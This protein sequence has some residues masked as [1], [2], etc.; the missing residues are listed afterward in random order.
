MT[1][2]HKYSSVTIAFSFLD[3]EALRDAIVKLAMARIPEQYKQYVTEDMVREHVD[4]IPEEYLE[5]T[6]EYL[7]K[8]KGKGAFKLSFYN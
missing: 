3:A 8:H 1:N 5:A 6:L 4:K 7:S 2:S